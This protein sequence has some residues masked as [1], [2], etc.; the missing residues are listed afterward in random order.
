MSCYWEDSE[1]Y[2]DIM[3]CV[4]KWNKLKNPVYIK[5]W[6]IRG[7]G[8]YQGKESYFYNPVEW[9]SELLEVYWVEDEAEFL[10]TIEDDSFHWFHPTIK[11]DITVN[12]L[13]KYVKKMKDH[14]ITI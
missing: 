13:E 11:A 12:D 1:A 3:R 6:F 8:E 10:I 5:A 14:E 7:N 9:L 2:E 4:N